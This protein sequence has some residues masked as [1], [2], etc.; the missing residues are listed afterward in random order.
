MVGDHRLAALAE[1]QWGVVSLR[2]LRAI[3]L[4]RGAVASRVRTGRLLRLHRSVYAVGHRA[5][6]TEGRWMAAVLAC[7]PDALLSHA[8][9]A[10]LWDIR[11]TNAERIDVIVPRDLRGRDGVAV[12]R[13]RLLTAEDA[14][15]VRRIPVTNVARTLLDLA[16]IVPTTDLER[17]VAQADVRGLLDGRELER[18]IAGA[19]GHRGAARLARAVTSGRDLTTSE[20]ERLFLTL[21]R[22]ARLP[23]PLVNTWLTVGGGEEI[24]VDFLWPI[25]RLVVEA[26]GYR[27]HR[28]RR[29][30]ESDRARDAQLVLAGY[31][32]IR[33]TH[34]RLVDDPAGVVRMLRRLLA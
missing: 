32:P 33:V 28:G 12:H 13:S 17:A 9:A 4:G 2:Q 30:F 1:R 14:A 24:K 7:G 16:A 18:T 8:S 23:Q 21:V 31:R 3:G 25:Q 20:L 11:P 29:A 34:R 15:V 10:R 26:D 5:L 6:S 19:D 22:A 27:F